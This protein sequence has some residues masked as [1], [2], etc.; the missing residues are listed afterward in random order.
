M[1][2]KIDSVFSGGGVK[3]FAYM[4]ALQAL[5]EHN[6]VVERVAG[7]S[8]GAIMAALLAA[9]FK[10]DD[11][12]KE[13]EHTD[14][15]RFLDSPKWSK[16]IPFNKWF[17]VYFQMG[18]YQGNALERWISSLLAKKGVHT[19]G[20]I[21]E[22]YLKVI[23]SDISLKKLIVIP[24]DLERVYGIEPESFSVATAVRMSAGFPYFF[25]PKKLRYAP[26][27]YSMMVDGGLLS[28]FPL[29]VFG[30]RDNTRKRPLLGFR[31][32]EK[33][34]PGQTKA[35]DNAL[36]M[37]QGLFSTM[38]LAHDTRFVSTEDDKNIIY[39]PVEGI[40]STDFNMDEKQI[41]QLGETGYDITNHF[42]MKWP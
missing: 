12:Q 39:I 33:D 41:S 37:F 20:D 16:L 27:K 26:D 2:M 29:W 18:I 19:F 21:K 8:A 1:F 25:M 22:G 40:Q 3:A 36:D 6:L 4:G 32:K 9:G 31:L 11:I 28:N 30:H 42:L 13:I 23:V 17:R 14:L 5:N 34:H 7:T 10:P 24:D 15:N 38:K 35:M